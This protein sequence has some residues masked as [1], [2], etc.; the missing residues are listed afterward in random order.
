M[1]TI[2]DLNSLYSE[3]ETADSELFSEQRSNVRL[4]SGDHYPNKNSRFWARIRDTKQI[5]QEAKI[6]ITKNHLQ[7]ITKTYVNNIL[8]HAP[9]V[10]VGPANDNEL[11]D[12]KAAEL[13]HSIWQDLK[14][15]QKI[16]QKIRGWAKDYIEIGEC[17]VKVFWDPSAGD[18][19]GFE[20][21]IERDEQG[22]PISDELGNVIPVLDENGQLVPTKKAVFTGAIQ[23]ERFF[24]FNVLRAASAKAMEDSPFICVRKMS[25][26][27]DLQAMVGDDEEK[28]KFIQSSSKDTFNV[29]EG[30]TGKYQNVKDQCMVREYYFRRCAEYPTGYYYITTEAGILFEGELPFG[31]FPIHYVGFDEAATSPRARSIIKV[32]RPYQAE[33]NRSYSKL[34]EHQITLGDDKLLIQA[35][36]KLA[37]GGS[38]AGVRGVQYSG[39]PPG[40]L[41]GRSGEQYLS[42]IN[43]NIQELY[44]VTNVYED[45]EETPSQ[46]EPYTLLYR[47]IRNKKKFSL[48]GEKFEEFL[49]AIC[50]TALDLAKNY[51][52]EDMLV[53][54]VGRREYINISEF[55]S[56]EKLCYLVKVEKQS[57]DIES[58]LG[59]QLAMNQVIQYASK[60]IG[61]E[62]IGRILKN[63]PFVNGDEAFADLTQDYENSVNDIL[64]LDR[65]QYPTTSQY[66]NLTYLIRR[67][68]SRTKQRDFDFL[69][70]PVRMNYQRKIAELEKAEAD[71][72]AAIQRAQSG[73]IPTTGYSVGC[74]FY[75]EDPAKPG[76]T[77]RAR[78][79]YDSLSWLLKKLE[80]QGTSLSALDGMN[81]GVLAEMGQYMP[82][83]NGQVQ[84]PG[85]QVG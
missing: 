40:I 1:K 66:E 13:A 8:A 9:G 44:S 51:Y 23:F 58:R 28:L 47:S 55:K 82:Q 24:A 22:N 53:P 74:D 29:F 18:L 70:V 16:N 78:V 4:V 46:M 26:I 12:Q 31:I 72:Q 79:P 21:E 39:A 2:A 52:T 76:T 61:S 48:Y 38:V 59:K 60:E 20:A 77:R 56:S 25:L 65:G 42:T 62:N 84:T 35:G 63:M 67:I 11:S 80:E 6:R 50:E 43:S 30:T 45:T 73:F 3:A 14:Y 64:A 71:K 81:E 33:I 83:G 49:V 19:K 10:A 75:V 85:M 57:D 54:A 41:Q 5:S 27:K 36:T 37:H 32:A 7:K 17:F 68:V 15:K 69:P 34:A